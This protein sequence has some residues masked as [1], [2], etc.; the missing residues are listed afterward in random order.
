M[1]PSELI[2]LA[3]QYSERTLAQRN[4]NAKLASECSITAQDITRQLLLQIPRLE[5][6]SLSDRLL[7]KETI[8]ALDRLATLRWDSRKEIP[9]CEL[10]ERL[11]LR[12]TEFASVSEELAMQIHQS[13]HYLGSPRPGGLHVGLFSRRSPTAKPYLISL[14]TLSKFDLNHLSVALNP[15][16]KKDMIIAGGFNVYPRE[17]EEVLFKHPQIQEA[18]VIGVPDPYRGENV[19]A[20][21][22]PKP[23]QKIDAEQVIAFCRERLAGYKVP[24][25]VE[26][27]TA[28]PKSGVGKYLRRELR[29]EETEARAATPSA[30]T[31]A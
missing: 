8:K 6:D 18:M 4:P 11:D 9:K 21:V 25:L 14:L 16:G 2:H 28:L 3:A 19:K 26:S 17:V 29:R 12:A 22:V 5:P 10:S 23:G 15:F 24:R 1:P 13:W 7:A 31:R 30:A 27:R 20:F